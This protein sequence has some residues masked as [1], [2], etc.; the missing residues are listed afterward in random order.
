MPEDKKRFFK[1]LSAVGLVLALAAGILIYRHAENF[2]S[3]DDAFIDAHIIPV[4]PRVAGQVTAVHISDNQLVKEGDVLIEIDP[5]DYE[6][7][8]AQQRANTAAEEAEARRAISDARRYEKIYKQDEISQQ[9]LE[10]AQ[11]TAASDQATLE[12]ERAALRQAELDLSYTKITAPESGRITK[13]AVEEGAYVQVGQ[14][15]FSIVP[16]QVWVTANFK[17]T[18][19][20]HV[21]PGQPVKIKVDTYPGRAFDGHVD[22][23]QSGTGERFSVMPPENATGNYVKVVQRI[24]VKILIDTPPDPDFPL[25]P[26]M[27]AVPTVRVR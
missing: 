20:T 25:R 7:K 23:V 19:L 9:Q 6:A 16:E 27:S 21:K 22:S 5:R 10:Q 11:S 17:E 18:Q 15:L 3:T 12:K 24:P 2:E 4:S 1:Q 14:T 8:A 26:G 13:K